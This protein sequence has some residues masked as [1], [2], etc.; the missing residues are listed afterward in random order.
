MRRVALVLALV[1][2]VEKPVGSAPDAAQAAAAGLQSVPPPAVPDA[3]PLPPERPQASPPEIPSPPPGKRRDVTEIVG[4]AYR[5]AAGDLD[6][7]KK[8]ELALASDA[9]L[10]V[11]DRTGR[12]LAEV[13]AASGAQVLAV[14]DADGDGRREL[15][16]GWG[17]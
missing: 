13:P 5:V 8:A 3:A 14:L 17:E 9:R 7:D 6:G 12:T 11:V 10:W 16:V 4:D 2:C 1:A 15:V